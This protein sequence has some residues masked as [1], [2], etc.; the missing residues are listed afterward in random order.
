MIIGPEPIIN[1][2]R[3]EVSL[4]IIAFKY[5]ATVSMRNE[6]ISRLS[7]RGAKIWFKEIPSN[8]KDHSG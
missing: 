4:G 8:K 2:E 1:T 3:I 5:E 6:V 7:C